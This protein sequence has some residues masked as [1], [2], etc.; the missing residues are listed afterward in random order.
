MPKSSKKKG[1][2]AGGTVS[3]A[4]NP[5]FASA[6]SASSTKSTGNLLD[7][8]K[9]YGQNF[10]KNP[11]II[12]A[13][14]QKSNI[15]PTDTV[16]EIG[17]G[18]GNLTVKLLERCARLNAIEYDPRMVREVTKRVEGT[19]E[20]NKLTVIHGDALKTAFPFFNVCVANVPYQISSGLV[21]KLL[22]HRPFFKCAVMMFQEEFAL[23]LSARPGESLYCRLSVNTQLLARV[24]QLMKV[25]R[26]NFRPPPKVESRVVRIEPRNPPPPVNFTE[27]DGMV[28]LLF[29]RKNKTIFSVL[30]NKST[31]KILEENV[32]TKAAFDNVKGAVEI[33][34]KKVIAEVCETEEY[35]DKRVTRLDIDDLLKLLAE[36]N[37][38]G[39][40]FA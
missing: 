27:W 20:S 5:N 9:A 33:D 32:K 15:K 18:T 38:R 11:A 16:L 25:G 34:V 12:D 39:I 37:E 17:P 10:L 7:P 13:I 14:V 22:G 40:H 30:N 6:A 31:Y 35:K 4:S 28:R 19:P 29:N 36:F 2:Y 8:V 1:S 3:A 21:F 24:D 23:R 26:N